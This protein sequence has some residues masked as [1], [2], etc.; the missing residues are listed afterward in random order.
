[1][2][3]IT[4]GNKP[5][6]YIGHPKTGSTSVRKALLELGAEEIHGQHGIDN[7]TANDVIFNGGIVCSGCRLPYELIVSWYHH[8]CIVNKPALTDPPTLYG[9]L[10]KALSNHPYLSKGTLF[11]GEGLSN[12]TIRFEAGIERQLNRYLGECGLPA[13]KLPHIN[14]TDHS[15]HRDYYGFAAVSLV[16][17]AFHKDFENYGYH[18]C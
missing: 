7:V 9:Y 13:V 1:M 12:R 2:Y 6:C 5:F 17:T 16:A 11:P 15:D 14:A 10:V 4:T 3:L 18:F 8:D